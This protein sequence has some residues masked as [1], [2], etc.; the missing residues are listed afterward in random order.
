MQ[1]FRVSTCVYKYVIHIIFV[2]EKTEEP[3]KNEDHDD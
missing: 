3:K 2:T 1:L